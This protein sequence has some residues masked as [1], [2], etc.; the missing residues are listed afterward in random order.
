MKR[1]L[2]ADAYINSIFDITPKGLREKG[3]SGLILDIDNTLVATNIR[4]ADDKIIHYI[5]SLIED[6]I[7]IIVVSNAGKKR[8]ETFCRP[9]KINYVYKAFKPLSRGFDRAIRKM[10]LPEE[11]VAIA[12]DQLFTDVLGGNIKGVHTILLKPIDLDEPFPLRIKR[13][14]ERPILA[15]HHFNDKY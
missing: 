9:L 11:K 14:F 3:I 1:L 5:K 8:V 7:K 2:T 10:G 6:G 12:G 4:D 13:I 15:K